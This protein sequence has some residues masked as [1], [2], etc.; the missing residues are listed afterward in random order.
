MSRRIKS[1]V[2]KSDLFGLKIAMFILLTKPRRWFQIV[3]LYKDKI[4]T[5]KL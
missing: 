5:D 1:V 2:I 4:L 3:S